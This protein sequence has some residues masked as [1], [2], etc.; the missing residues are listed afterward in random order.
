MSNIGKQN[1]II[2][3]SV[4]VTINNSNIIV[5]GKLGELSIDY[6]NIIKIKKIESKIHLER[7]S[8]NRKDRSLHGLYRALIN[9]MIVGV[10]EGFSKKLQL[11]GVGY[12]V[13]LKKDFLIVNAGY[14]HPI[15]IQIPNEIKIETPNAT[16]IIVHGINKQ[17]VGDLSAKIREIRSPEP[18]KGK[19]IK[20]SYEVIRRKAG[21]TVGAAT[22]A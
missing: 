7:K 1:I 3:D 15:Y 2:P 11:N 12:T 9:N 4:D 18:Y 22:G 21:K 5:I 17:N 6:N 19:G 8:D 16:T 20:Y 14:S 13:E 10:T